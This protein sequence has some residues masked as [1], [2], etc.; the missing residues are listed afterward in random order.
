DIADLIRH[1]LDRF[2]ARHRGPVRDLDA[3]TV[4]ALVRYDWP[5]NVREL[6]NVIERL[7]VT[8]RRSVIHVAD[9]PPEISTAVMADAS[10]PHQERQRTAVDDLY[11]R[12]VREH[13]T[14]WAVVYPLYMQREITRTNVRE[15]VRRALAESRGSYKL[16]ARMFNV[17]MAD[18]KRFLN[19]LRKH[20]CQV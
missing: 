3:D 9:L 2:T 14:F 5:G 18:Y 6:E 4:A 11:E 20:E 17:E 19:F 1:F 7:V 16:V 10:R 13:Q 8:G 12:M 15:L